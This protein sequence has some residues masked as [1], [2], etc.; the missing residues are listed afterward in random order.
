MGIDRL[1]VG[2]GGDL[3][4]LLF[5]LGVLFTGCTDVSFRKDFSGNVN[6]CSFWGKG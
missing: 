6:V 3:N 2:L 5:G 4:L 1:G